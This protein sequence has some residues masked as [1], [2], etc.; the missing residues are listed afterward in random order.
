MKQSFLKLATLMFSNPENDSKK[1]Y[2]I[3]VQ[4]INV[5]YTINDIEATRMVLQD[6][7]SKLSTDDYKTILYLLN[8]QTELILYNN[9]QFT[10]NRYSTVDIANFLKTASYFQCDA[11]LLHLEQNKVS[12]QN[13]R[14][15]L[16][17]YKAIFNRMVDKRKNELIAELQKYAS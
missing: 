7:I 2:K 10:Q 15:N 13:H 9:K 12:Y 11:V 1:Q 14:N 16:D 4:Y 6:V 17:H 5:C 8:Y 3:M